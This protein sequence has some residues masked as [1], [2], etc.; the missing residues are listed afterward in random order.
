MEIFSHKEHKDHKEM[1]TIRRKVLSY[2][3]FAIFVA[4]KLKAWNWLL[5]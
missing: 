1:E 3:Y 5:V 2:V 4:K